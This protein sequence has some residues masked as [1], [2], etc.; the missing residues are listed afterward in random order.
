MQATAAAR[1]Q[2]NEKPKAYTFSLKTPYMKQG[3]VTQLVAETENMWIHTKINAE[4]GENEIHTHLDEDHSFIV[5]EGQ[6]SVFDETGREMKVEKYQGVMIPK[7]AYYRYLNTGAGNLVVLRIGA[8]VK[9]QPQRGAVMRV[10]P[11]GRPLP[12]ESLENK[13][14]P[15]IEDTGKF[16][17]ESAG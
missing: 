6:M 7:G 11:D 5:L 4:G 3:R 14:L 10:R 16:F 1:K 13:T 2:T 15:P 17:A 8:G 9:G 12:A